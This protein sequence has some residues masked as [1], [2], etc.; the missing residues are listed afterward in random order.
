MAF[1]TNHGLVVGL[2][3]RQRPRFPRLSV[4]LTQHSMMKRLPFI[5]AAIKGQDR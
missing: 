5:L 1:K 3:D 4:T 2:T